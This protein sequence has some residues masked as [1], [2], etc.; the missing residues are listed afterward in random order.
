MPIIPDEARTFGMEGMFRQLGIYSSEGQL[1]QP[2][3]FGEIASYRESKDG[4]VLEEGINE[5]GAFAAWLSAATSYSTHRY[6]LVPFYIFYSMFG[7]QRVGDLAWAAG[8]MQARGFLMGATAGRTTLN[9]EGLQHQDGHSHLLASA[10]PNCVAY[11]PC[12]AFELAVI[13]HDGLRRMFGEGERV[14]YYV[15]LMNE[16]Y[17]QPALPESQGGPDSVEAHIL[18]GM[19][20]LES[21]GDDGTGGK[22]VRLLG[23]GAILREVR[24][25]AR[26]LHEQHGVASE[27]YSVTSF[28]ELARDG[29]DVARWNLLHADEPPRRSHVAQCLDGDAPVIAATDYVKAL[30]EGIRGHFQA[31]Y[32]VL[33]T[34]G[35]GRSDT[36]AKLRDFFEVDERF[37]TLAALRELQDRQVVSAAE[38]AGAMREMG[39]S[40]DKANPRLS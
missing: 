21:V 25:A 30:A 40:P 15:T 12:Y 38:V 26:R 6:T 11:D 13:V 8:D 32:R 17:A 2:E 34:D 3:D 4:Q 18:R 1:Y 27:V 9:G 7:F 37:V 31:P 36:R 33:G 10:I 39:I 29:S 22:R 20:K 35:F 28:T 19:Y 24:K 14:F 5:S 23:S 16:N